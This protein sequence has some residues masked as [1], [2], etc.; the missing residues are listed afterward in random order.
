MT[1]Y[2]TLRKEY[3]LMYK[4]LKS[5][6]KKF[7]K[8]KYKSVVDLN[9]DYEKFQKTV[10]EWDSKLEGLSK[11]T[12]TISLDEALKFVDNE[13]HGYTHILDSLNDLIKTIDEMK[14]VAEETAKRAE[15]L[16]SDIIP[17]HVNIFKRITTAI[18]KTVTKFISRLIAVNVLVFA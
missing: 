8:V 14:H 13:K 17:K 11:K 12:V 2:I 16:G 3:K 15:T 6:A 7:I 1:D 5:Y 10:D 9:N 18:S 4:D